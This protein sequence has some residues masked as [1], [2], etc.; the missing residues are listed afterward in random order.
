MTFHTDGVVVKAAEIES[1]LEW[2]VFGRL[3]PP[4]NRYLLLFGEMRVFCW[5]PRRT[6][7]STDDERR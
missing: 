5:I 4:S 2:T 7:G 6:F 3:Y 1:R